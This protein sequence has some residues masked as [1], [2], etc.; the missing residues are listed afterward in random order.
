MLDLDSKFYEF[1]ENVEVSDNKLDT[2][3]KGRDA[4]RE[5][6]KNAFYEKGKTKP[7]FYM[8]GSYRMGT[9]IQ[10]L[11]DIEYDIDDG[12]YL[13]HFNGAEKNEWDSVNDIHN[14]VY[15]IVEN[16]TQNVEDKKT[17]IRVSYANNYHL[18]LPIY[19]VKDDVAYLAH[20]DKGWT[21]SD[22]KALGEWFLKHVKKDG[23]KL[24]D[25]VKLVKAWKDYLNYDNE[26]IDLCGLAI[27]ILMA[28]NF[29][30]DDSLVSAL[31][32]TITELIDVI[33]V[34]CV[35]YKPVNPTDEDLF[36]SLSYYQ[37]NDII[38]NL[39]SFNDVLE[40]ARNAE[41]EK[42]ACESLKLIFGDRFPSGSENVKNQKYI[43]TAAPAVINEDGRSA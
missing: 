16:H 19:I 20:L 2:I 37:K 31:I 1:L 33:E 29:I 6:I 11:P 22:P 25:C 17:C 27:T 23:E 4:I 15:G 36:S 38:S 34:D 41:N 21:E 5:K 12:I 32:Q 40:D 8:Q 14:E 3:K 10:T 9:M 24:R 39:K 7:N 30:I 42:I 28:N 13:Q 18:D 26:V 35:C 43:K